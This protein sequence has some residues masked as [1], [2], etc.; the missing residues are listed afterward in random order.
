MGD[1]VKNL[2]Q[3][4][5]K[6]DG[7]S[8]R[9]AIVHARWNKSVIDALIAGALAKLKEAGVKESNIVLQSVPGSFELPLACQR[10]FGG[11]R[12]QHA[13]SATPIAG[14]APALATIA[15]GHNRPFDA[16]I[17]IGV[18]IKG[19]TMHFEYICESVSH[20]LMRVQLDS[21]VP[22]IFGRAGIGRVNKGHNHGEDWGAAAVEMASRVRRWGEGKF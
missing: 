6:F 9:I 7:S 1:T 4:T 11:P 2:P 12:H 18:L 20:A 16:V 3:F 21:G 22:V 15:T 14:S 13:R 10:S 17:A 19:S 8:L 5:E